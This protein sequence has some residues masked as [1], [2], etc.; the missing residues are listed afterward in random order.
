MSR[1]HYDV[2]G[3]AQGPYNTCW[4]ACFRM[5]ITF[6]IQ[7]GRPVNAQARALLE[8]EL[9][10]QF[11]RLNRGL[12]PVRFE[13]VAAEFGLS[14]LHIA[15]LTRPLRASELEIPL[16][17]YD[18]LQRRGPFS[19][20]GILPNGA[21]HAIVICGASDDAPSYDIEFIDP[22]YG[23]MRHLSSADLR[24]GFTPDGGALFVF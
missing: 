9:I 7:V 3:I 21:G 4:L 23:N 6:R 2:R 17:A 20:G 24:R 14:A 15:G 18:V 13:T 19:L 11:E 16:L 1:I 8:P 12:D 5:L 22:R 10:S